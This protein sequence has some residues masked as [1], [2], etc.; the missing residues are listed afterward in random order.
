M[1]AH[2]QRGDTLIEVV[3]AL[4]IL[5]SVL[6]AS[7]NVATAAFRQGRSAQERT[8]AVNLIQEQAEGL[9]NIRDTRSWGMFRGAVFGAGTFHM[10]DAG[11]SWQVNSGMLNNGIYRISVHANGS[12]GA[13]TGIT[14]VEAGEKIRF[15][16]AAEWDNA[17]VGPPNRTVISTYLVNLD[18][19]GPRDCSA[20][21][22]GC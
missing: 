21:G 3:M 20:G 8:Q 6:L 10:S 12:V 7:F 9:R 1:R 17:G 16:I 15:D 5:S 4:A 22:A 11:G 2:A 14:A 13:T 18:G 19:M